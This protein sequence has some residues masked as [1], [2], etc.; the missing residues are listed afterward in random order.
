MFYQL[1]IVF[2]RSRCRN[3]G[4]H[5]L[6]VSVCTGIRLEG[7]GTVQFV[8]VSVKYEYEAARRPSYWSPSCVSNPHLNASFDVWPYP[9]SF[10]VTGATVECAQ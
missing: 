9:Q 10:S 3:F 1:L 8:D 5:T 7:A 2:K 6:C 4:C